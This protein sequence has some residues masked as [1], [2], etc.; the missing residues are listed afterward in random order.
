MFT[1]LFDARDANEVATVRLCELLHCYKFMAKFDEKIWWVLAN[2][3]GMK[4]VVP[5]I[6]KWKLL[7]KGNG[8]K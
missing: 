7:D 1:N 4:N 6:M 8:K 3:I 2:F 5:L